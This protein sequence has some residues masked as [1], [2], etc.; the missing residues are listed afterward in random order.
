MTVG[1]VSFVG[2]VIGY[3]FLAYVFFVAFVVC[4]TVFHFLNAYFD[5]DIKDKNAEKFLGVLRG[6]KDLNI[7]CLFLPVVFIVMFFLIFGEKN[8][9]INVLIASLASHICFI[10]IIWFDLKNQI[11]TDIYEKLYLMFYFLP[12]VLIFLAINLPLSSF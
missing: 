4:K 9:G 8:T 11:R 10:G 3:W 1:G 2:L 6:T 5:K 12:P 7:I